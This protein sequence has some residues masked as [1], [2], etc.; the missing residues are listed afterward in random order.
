MYG[1]LEES[2]PA[3]APALGPAEIKFVRKMMATST[4]D[5]ARP[6]GLSHESQ[7]SSASTL[8]T[9]AT[10]VM[11]ASTLAKLEAA[12]DE[13]ELQPS[14]WD[15]SLF[16]F[17]P[18]AGR[19]ASLFAFLLLAVNVFLQGSFAFYLVDGLDDKPLT[20][21]DVN[22]LKWWRRHVAHSLE[23]YNEEKGES[24]ARRV[25]NDDYGVEGSGVQSNSV[26][27][28]TSVSG[29]PDNSS[30][31]HFSA[32]TRPIPLGRAAIVRCSRRRIQ[33]STLFAAKREDAATRAACRRT[34]G[35]AR[36]RPPVI[37]LYCIYTPSPHSL[38]TFY[39]V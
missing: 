8:P 11:S 22:E 20:N 6:A 36:G 7:A 28:S 19:S 24:L 31:S 16:L 17:N 10:Q 29:A 18:V 33:I 4:G 14:V 23:F 5:D 37:K 25:C 9:L 3:A 1:S 30:L 12:S 34:S 27:K 35:T 13:V 26:W 15:S 39:S 38:R 21:D 2:T 32:M